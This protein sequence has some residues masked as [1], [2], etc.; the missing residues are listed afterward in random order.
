MRNIKLYR[1]GLFA[2]LL[3]ISGS[4]PISSV[5]AHG[6]ASGVDL[7]VCRIPVE[8]HWVHFTAYQPSLTGDREF[9]SALPGLGQTNLVFDYESKALRHMTVEFEITKEPEGKR[10]YH[11][12]PK[13][14]PTG[15]V[16]AVVNFTEPG[17]YLAHV[18]LVNE[19]KRTD[20][21][22]PFGVG[23]GESKLNATN[24]II[25]LVVIFGLLYFVYLSNASFKEKVDS[26]LKK[27]KE[28]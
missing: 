13:E 5:W 8:S 15:S 10:V 26:M 9:C 7:D 14:Y 6:G 16:N 28:V 4:L 2:L 20:A 24:I 22:I 1:N 21:H 11:Q 18:T 19:G 25:A 17:D 27:A 12:D 23:V 3:M